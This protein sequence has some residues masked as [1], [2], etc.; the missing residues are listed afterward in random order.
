MKKKYFILSA[1]AVI[2]LV[3][4][5]AVSLRINNTW[6]AI[7][8]L[9]LN[10]DL[11]IGIGILEGDFPD[12]SA[13]ERT[14]GFGC[15]ELAGNGIVYGISGFPDVTDDYRTTNITITSAEFSV[16]GIS[17]GDRFSEETENILRKAGLTKNEDRILS[18]EKGKL[19]ITFQLK[20][21]MIQSIRIYLSSTNRRGVHF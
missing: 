1:L 4:V 13:Y 9:N 20:G 8:K 3:I 11:P 21:E 10:S 15:Y 12:I 19:S 14:D 6:S 17:V 18:F 7:R 5:A 2:I 16:F